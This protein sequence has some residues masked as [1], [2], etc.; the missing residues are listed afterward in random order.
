MD[1]LRDGNL[2]TADLSLAAWRL[3]DDPVFF[4]QVIAVLEDR[5]VF[6]QVLFSYALHHD[7]KG[8]MS[9]FLLHQAGFLD[10]CGP[11]LESPLVTIDPVLRRQYEHLDY[12]PLVNARV[13][14]LGARR[15]IPNEGLYTQYHGLL[16]A[17]ACKRELRSD[18]RLALAT[19]LLAQ[20]RAAEAVEQFTGI[21]P[22]ETG[23]RLQ[24]A[25]LGSVLALYRGDSETARAIAAPF[26][27]HPVERWRDRFSTVLAHLD[28]A[29]GGVPDGNRPGGRQAE[30][31]TLA[32]SDPYLELQGGDGELKLVY[33]NASEV[34][35]N[36]YEMDLEFLFSTGPFLDGD[37]ERFSFI[38]PNRSDSMATVADATAMTIAIP[39]EYNAKNVLVEVRAGGARAA[40]PHF[41]NQIDVTLSPS[42]GQLQVLHEDDRRPLPRAY[43][44]VYAQ[45]EAGT[46]FYKDGYTDLRGRF[47][48]ASLTRL[49][50]RDPRGSTVRPARP[51]GGSRCHGVRGCPAGPVE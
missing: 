27:E 10:A 21:D 38:R 7:R 11:A 50:R 35:V 19:Y 51:L 9:E 42:Y 2:F 6:D 37:N 49:R 22:A 5:Q 40:V 29:A 14:K 24:L 8:V 33:R 4:V 36:Y 17:L 23:S 28:E 48:Y 15:T 34:T 47:D 32:S 41:A 30:Q 46:R 18:D 16:D 45:T 25:Y 13:H 43:I 39:D 31:E 12:E 3:R 1:F 44:K 26:A 20:D